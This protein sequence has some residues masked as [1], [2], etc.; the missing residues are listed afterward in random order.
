MN[1]YEQHLTYVL[2]YKQ[3]MFRIENSR[4]Y[5]SISIKTYDVLGSKIMFRSCLDGIK[6]VGDKLKMLQ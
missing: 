4:S 5:H 1:S 2:T 6:Y 3:D